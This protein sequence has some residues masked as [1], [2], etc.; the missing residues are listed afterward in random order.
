MVKIRREYKKPKIKSSKIKALSFYARNSLADPAIHE[1]L[2]A[3]TI[4]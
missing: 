4:E 2:L 3:V 1:Y